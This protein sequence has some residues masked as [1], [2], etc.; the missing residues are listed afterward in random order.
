MSTGALFSKALLTLKTNSQRTAQVF[1][2]LF[3]EGLATARSN[4][5]PKN[6]K[7]TTPLKVCVLP[8][9]R[10]FI[11]EQAK[12]CGRTTSTYLRDLALGYQPQSKTDLDVVR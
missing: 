8:E 10:T 5:K 12:L 3:S 11:Q 1:L 4:M 6:R 2:I 7:T 9:E